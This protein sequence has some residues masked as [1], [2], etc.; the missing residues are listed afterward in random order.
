MKTVLAISEHFLW[1][2]DIAKRIMWIMSVNSHLK[3]EEMGSGQFDLLPG[4]SYRALGRCGW[5]DNPGLS[6]GFF[7]RTTALPSHS[8]W[9]CI[10]LLLN[11]VIFITPSSA[12]D[13]T[14]MLNTRWSIDQLMPPHQLKAFIDTSFNTIYVSHRS[15]EVCGI[16]GNNINSVNWVLDRMICS[17]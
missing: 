3:V 8:H 12:W 15:C 6:W 11:Q 1:V 9:P 2:R 17:I 4:V 14:Q 5:D 13:T 10:L 16:C 7:L